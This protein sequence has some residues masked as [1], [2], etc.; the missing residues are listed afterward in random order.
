MTKER[1]IKPKDYAAPQ[2]S[3][4]CPGC[5]NFGILRAIQ[6]ALAELVLPHDQVAVFGGIGCSGKTPY[7][8]STN[9]IHTLHGR[10]LPFAMGAKL[11]NPALTV[12]A[13]GGDG[14]GLSIGAGHFVNAARRNVDLTYILFNN[15]VYGLTKGQGAPT[16]KQGEQTRSMAAPTELAALDPLSLAVASGYSWIGRGY[17]FDVT[18]LIRLLTEAIRHPGSAIL[19]VLQ[20]CPTYNDINTRDWYSG[21]DPETG[22]PRLYDVA[23]AGHTTTIPADAGDDEVAAV[24]AACFERILQRDGRIPLG[25]FLQDC[26]RPVAAGALNAPSGAIADERGKSLT[27]L[28][29]LLDTLRIG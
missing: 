11:A 7:Y 24:R 3:D 14:D 8:L 6:G 21:S 22:L 23:E 27:D 4:W 1:T 29:S 25:L 13:V 19:E 20:P 17:A 5:G 9:G 16:L 2:P 15:G 26:S 28:S 18:Q 10:A 12:L